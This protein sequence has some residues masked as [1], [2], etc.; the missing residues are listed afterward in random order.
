M[1]IIPELVLLWA[2]L[3]RAILDYNG[4]CTANGHETKFM[5]M[6]RAKLWINSKRDDEFSF[7]WIC[8]HLD[9]DPDYIRKHLKSLPCNK[10]PSERSAVILT[11]DDEADPYPLG[12]ERETDRQG[13]EDLVELEEKRA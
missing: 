1:H 5:I 7:H 3:E 4:G 11:L 13:G 10:G 2:I 12:V 6:R 9:L 8:T